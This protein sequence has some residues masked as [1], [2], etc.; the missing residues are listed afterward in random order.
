MDLR[1]PAPPPFTGGR[2]RQAIP[3]GQDRPGGEN[4][5]AYHKCKVMM[6]DCRES[7]APRSLYLTNY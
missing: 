7:P 1:I 5:R 6:R 4:G 3:N 2:A